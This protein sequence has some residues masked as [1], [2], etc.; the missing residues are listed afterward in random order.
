MLIQCP[1]FIASRFISDLEKIASGCDAA[2]ASQSKAKKYKAKQP[3]QDREARGGLDRARQ[4]K[5][6]HGWVARIGK[7]MEGYGGAGHSMAGQAEAE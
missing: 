1:N 2:I 7:G 4:G 6:G 5:V 3:A